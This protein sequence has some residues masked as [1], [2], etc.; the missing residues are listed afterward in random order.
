MFSLNVK[1]MIY[2]TIFDDL[3]KPVSAIGVGQDI[4]AQKLDEEKYNRMYQQLS[5]VNPYSMGS[6]R[7]NLTRNLCGDGQSPYDSVLAQQ[8]DGT[9]DGYLEA[10]S[11]IIADE[12][13]KSVFC[14]GFT[15][16]KMMEAF[17]SGL[18][19]DF[20]EYPVWSSKREIIW[21]DA[22]VNMVK[23]PKT[24]DIE[25]VTYALNVTDRKN[26]ENIV[27]RISEEKFDHIGL[28]NLTR[29]LMNCFEKTGNLEKWSQTR[30]KIMIWL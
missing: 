22:F 17:R 26:E 5:R 24:R 19:T 28:I 23:N 14:Q 7:L 25:A 18:E 12:K 20:I 4:T 6:F 9:V 1:K 13:I 2:T 16:E 30:R 10:N 8:K 15:R 11:S 21:I 29:G 27:S 3:G